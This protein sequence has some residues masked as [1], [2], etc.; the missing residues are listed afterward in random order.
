M[1]VTRIVGSLAGSGIEPEQ[2][3]CVCMYRAQSE[4]IRK[5]LEEAGLMGVTVSTVDAFQVGAPSE[6]LPAHAVI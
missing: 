3:G 2:I 5:M 6:R 4:T 1:R